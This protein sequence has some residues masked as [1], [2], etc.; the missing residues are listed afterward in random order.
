[1]DYLSLLEHTNNML[2]E[3]FPLQSIHVIL[4]VKGNAVPKL[5]AQ[6][7]TLTIRITWTRC[8]MFGLLLLLYSLAHLHQS[9][10]AS[11]FACLSV[12]R[13][14]ESDQLRDSLG[15]KWN[16]VFFIAEDSAILD[17]SLDIVTSRKVC[18]VLHCTLCNYA[19]L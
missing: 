12:C 4:V 11:G 18:I 9:I 17:A 1:M 3:Q 10:R 16:G 14:P 15:N 19:L 13:P 7:S 8:F 5:S 6:V 2:K